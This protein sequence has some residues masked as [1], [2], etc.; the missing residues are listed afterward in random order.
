MIVSTYAG[1]LALVFI[2]L[3]V[4]VVARRYQLRSAL[5]DADDFEMKRRI[6]AHANFAEYTP[7]F[8]I[9]MGFAEHERLSPSYIH[10]LC[11]LFLLG[12]ISHAS[13]VL[14]LEKY[15][16]GKLV[17]YPK[18]RMVGM[19]ASFSA[20]IITALVLIFNY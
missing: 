17:A 18:F 7:L 2:G 6:R 14:K 16:N 20:I 8:L 15:E 10:I 5:G 13:S 9:L 1:L 12:R 3:S 19:V 11:M 4:N